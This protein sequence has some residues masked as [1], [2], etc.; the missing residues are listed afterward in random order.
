MFKYCD[1]VLACE[2][3][4]LLEVAART[5][6]PTYVYSAAGIRQQFHRLRAALQ[7]LDHSIHYAVKTNSNL[8]VLGTLARIGSGFDIVSGGELS[9]LQRLGVAGD[10]IVFAGVGKTADEMGLALRAGVGLFNVESWEE[11]E[12]LA[13]VASDLNA[14]AR[15][16]MRVNPD[17]E[18]GAH[19]Y[20]STGTASEKFGIPYRE[21]V[22]LYARASRLPSLA[23]CGLHCHLGSQILDTEV[24]RQVAVRL[25]R[26]IEKL[27]AIGLTV[28]SANFGGGLGIR[29]RDEQ[30]PPPEQYVAA[31][32]PP[33]GHLGVRFLVEPGRFLVGNAG[34]LLTRVLRRKESSDKTFVV[35]DAAMN[36]LVRPSL[37]S[38][39]HG[40]LPLRR[41]ID[42]PVETVDVVGPV[43]ESGD[44]LA[45][46]R[47]LPRLETD[48]IIA[49]CSAGAY[50]FSMSSNY[51]SR[52]RAAE[53]LVDGATHR[54]VRERESTDDLVRGET[55]WDCA[56]RGA[57]ITARS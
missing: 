3:V 7:P 21:V 4:S 18:A 37:Y 35:V 50:G 27:R 40:I 57:D 39:Y 29:Y 52:P 55:D 46:A 24:Y 42:R 20:I 54:I 13:R 10:R 30:P 56:D 31:I 45:R 17:V 22:E 41:Q 33:L 51:N 34:V 12:L 23:P 38:A 53:V 2:Q 9:R 36:D 47:E 15:I 43:C 44:F 48:E 16:A 28:E 11:A 8:A 1:E 6:T 25:A 14:V 49:V 5:G 26:L 19:R 32:A